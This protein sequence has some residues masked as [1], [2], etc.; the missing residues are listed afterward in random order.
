MC[1][2]VPPQH[3]QVFSSV[4]KITDVLFLN[5]LLPSAVQQQWRFCFSTGIH[6]ESFA[7][8]LGL[9][10]DKGPTVIIVRDKENN[11]FGGYASE[12]WTVGPNFRGKLYLN[13]L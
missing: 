6:G 5:L 9:I 12:N 13:M 3:K 7:K 1:K 11:V 4:L 8:M 2:G 10:V